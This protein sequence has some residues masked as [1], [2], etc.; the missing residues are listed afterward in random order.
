TE[1]DPA[2]PRVAVEPAVHRLREVAAGLHEE[3][4]HRDI[5]QV[6]RREE[7]GRR[8]DGGTAHRTAVGQ[9]E[10]HG[11]A[12][13]VADD[14]RAVEVELDEEP[15]EL[16]RVAAHRVP[17]GTP[18]RRRLPVAGQVDDD[19][20]VPPGVEQLGNL[21]PGLTPVA[22]AVDEDDRLAGTLETLVRDGALHG[23]DVTD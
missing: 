9:L 23:T 10:R 2:E 15:L 21:T 7:A 8:E 12:E 5:R 17:V 11:A 6:V 20:V 18:G 4:V 19:D 13:G 14:V 3:E 22:D 16:L 1:G